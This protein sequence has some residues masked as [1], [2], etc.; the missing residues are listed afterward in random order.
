MKILAADQKRQPARGTIRPL[1][2]HVASDDPRR[3]RMVS[4]LLEF[5]HEI[6][7]YCP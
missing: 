7:E 5:G 4:R 3:R 6:L 2:S 1:R